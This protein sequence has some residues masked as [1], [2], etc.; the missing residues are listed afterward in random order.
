MKCSSFWMSGRAT[1]TID[2]SRAF[3]N[4]ARHTTTSAHQRTPAGPGRA[5]RGGGVGGGHVP[6]PPVRRAIHQ[7]SGR[8]PADRWIARAAGRCNTPPM[9]PPIRPR[10]V[11]DHPADPAGRRRLAGRP[12]RGRDPGRVLVVLGLVD[13]HDRCGRHHVLCTASA[14]RHPGDGRPG[15]RVDD[16]LERHLVRRHGDPGP[17]VPRRPPPPTAPPSMRAAARN[18][19][20]RPDGSGVE[21]ARRHRHHRPGHPR[22][23]PHQGP[24][25]PPATTC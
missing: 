17:L 23:L 2:E 14:A 12:R 18:P 22:R 1:F 20:D 5:D 24:P 13:H 7:I 16:R 11:P 6:I 4:M 8:R 3:M 9:R 15:G 21:P 25:R 19:P 10:P